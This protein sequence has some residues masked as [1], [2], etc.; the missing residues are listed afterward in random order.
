MLRRFS[1]ASKVRPEA[2][3]MTHPPKHA[4]PKCGADISPVLATDCAAAGEF[5]CR[6]IAATYQPADTTQLY[7]TTENTNETAAK[8]E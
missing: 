1:L 6:P 5:A 7:R 3:F 8:P 4:C 2:I